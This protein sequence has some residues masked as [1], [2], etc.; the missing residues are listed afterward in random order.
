MNKLIEQTYKNEE[1]YQS[2][3]DDCNAIV[4]ETVFNSRWTLVAGY[5][6][7]GK[8]IEDEIRTRPISLIQLFKDL[9]KSISNCSTGTLYH[10]HQFY[11]KF[12]R[13]DKVPEGKNISWT[14]IVTKY[15]PSKKEETQEV[16]EECSHSW[17]CT[18]CGQRR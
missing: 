14:K 7:L 1:W 4:V 15:L 8:R 10:A 17:V 6:E 12:P 11:V 16:R 5:H 3:S 13:L 18:N 2:L 9:A